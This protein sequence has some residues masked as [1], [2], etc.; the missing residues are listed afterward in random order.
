M[1]PNDPNHNP[2]EADRIQYES[3]RKKCLQLSEELAELLELELGY[4]AP[5]NYEHDEAQCLAKLAK[6]IENSL[7]KIRKD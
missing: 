3:F 2:N 5:T 6:Q 1:N 4:Y 7:H